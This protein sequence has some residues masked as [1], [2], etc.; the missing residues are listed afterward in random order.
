MVARCQWN[1]V[2]ATMTSCI[3]DLSPEKL[4]FTSDTHFWHSETFSQAHRPFASLEEMNET[5]IGNWNKVVPEDGTVFHLG[6]FC[7]R[8]ED[9][10]NQILDRLKGNIYLLIGNHDRQFINRP[11][12]ERFAGVFEQLC[13]NVEGQLI[14][15]NHFPMLAF[16]GKR[17]KAWQLCGHIHSSQHGSNVI[18]TDRMAMLMPTQYDVGVDNNGFTPVSYEAISKIMQWQIQT[19]QRFQ[20]WSQKV[21]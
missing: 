16:G 2:H 7:L 1:H 14:L 15:L 20:S 12:M 21:A 4:F 9:L 10:W 5:I 3:T 18:S 6:D 11:V 19:G 13:L 17:T 8:D